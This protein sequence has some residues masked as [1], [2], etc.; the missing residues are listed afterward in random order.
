MR[1]IDEGIRDVLEV[2]GINIDDN[3]VD[4]VTYTDLNLSYE[5]EAGDTVL[6][7]FANVTNLLDEEP[8]VIASCGF[9]FGNCSQVNPGLYDVIGR[10]YTLGVRLAF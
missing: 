6:N 5:V 9:F 3:T 7:F 8:P 1:W 4:S 10:R 2:E